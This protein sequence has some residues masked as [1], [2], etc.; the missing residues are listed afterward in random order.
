MSTLKPLH[1]VIHSVTCSTLAAVCGTL[2]NV[3]PC[4]CGHCASLGFAH[5]RAHFLKVLAHRVDLCG[6]RSLC[7]VSIDL[8]RV[9]ARHREFLR[10]RFHLAQTVDS[11]GPSSAFPHAL[12]LLCCTSPLPCCSF[13]PQVGSCCPQTNGWL[14]INFPSN[15]SFS[16][17][18][19]LQDRVRPSLAVPS[20]TA[21]PISAASCNSCMRLVF[22]TGC[23]DVLFAN[24]SSNR[25]P[26]CLDQ[27]P[28]QTSGP[29]A[30][31]ETTCQNAGCTTS[32]DVA[33]SVANWKTSR[34]CVSTS[35]KPVSRAGSSLPPAA[36]SASVL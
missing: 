20:F 3:K 4:D 17:S 8:N 1:I 30:A 19:D 23:V 24:R 35:P 36:E 6:G 7:S 25:V 13:D 28:Q 12:P 26:Q 33:V 15:L 21:L 5:H 34:R 22:V 11:L 31:L 29:R 2:L 10:L 32:D 27:F 9:D 18:V 14:T 16:R